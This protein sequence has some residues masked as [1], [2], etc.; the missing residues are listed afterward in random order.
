M[1]KIHEPLQAALDAY[2]SRVTPLTEIPKKLQEYPNP[3]EENVR[4]AE[5][6]QL[7][8][9]TQTTF[10]GP[11]PALRR[12]HVS[13][14]PDLETIQEV[15]SSQERESS[16]G[17]P[18][19]RSNQNATKESIPEMDEHQA[20]EL[21]EEV[22]KNAM[23]HWSDDNISPPFSEMDLERRSL[24]KNGIGTLQEE[25]RTPESQTHPSDLGRYIYKTPTVQI[26]SMERPKTSTPEPDELQA[27]LS[28]P[29]KCTLPLIELMKIRPALWESLT[30]KLD[31]QGVLNR[32]RF[33]QV[34]TAKTTYYEPV[35]LKKV[36][37]I[38]S[39]D[40]GNTT[41]PVLHEGIE[42]IAILDSGAGISIATKS[43]WEKWGRPTVRQTRMNLQLA[44]G[45]LENPIGL[46]EN[47][48]VTSCGIEYEHTFAIVDFGQNTNYEVILGQPFMRQFQMVQDWGYNYLYLRHETAITRVNLNN[49][50]H[51]DVTHMPMEEFDS[52]SSENSDSSDEQ[53]E[54]LWMCGA[55]KASVVTDGSEW[56]KDVMDEAYVP[57]PYPEEKFEP[58]EWPHCLATL[59]VCTLNHGT[60]LCDEDGYDII[61]I[62]MV[63]VI[64]HDNVKALPF[65]KERFHQEEVSIK[66]LSSADNA[67]GEQSDD[68]DFIVPKAEL[69]K[70]RMLL[71]GRNEIELE[72]P[73]DKSKRRFCKSHRSSRK[74]E[75]KEKREKKKKKEREA[76]IKDNC[77]PPQFSG[78]NEYLYYVGSEDAV[79]DRGQMAIWL[80]VGA[81]SHGQISG[82]TQ[83]EERMSQAK[84]QVQ[85]FNNKVG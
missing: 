16:L 65:V 28:A 73:C 13:K 85:T 10:E 5:H 45:S 17:M 1:D 47:I 59:D 3:R 69:E 35:K 62:R 20:Q 39:K 71:K 32:G 63:A 55:S 53:R 79:K 81:T 14:R 67:D 25:V 33:D 78:K 72:I 60:K 4:L 24:D 64:E 75:L 40:E 50:T 58:V 56:C 8:R 82:S 41:L 15:S 23:E 21:W 54:N 30:E 77:L 66:D 22:H 2:S 12:G 76:F 42:S 26:P 52:A 27:I 7:I 38:Q 70:V 29:I 51:R 49:H 36:N 11:P 61:P 57:I 48:I 74:Q 6:Q 84:E 46:L 18:T 9:D 43:I 34:N 19:A 80:S 31:E 37:K 44:D 83:K 68:E